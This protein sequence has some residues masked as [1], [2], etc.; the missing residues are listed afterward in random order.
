M[1]QG[2][3]ESRMR[4]KRQREFANM[5]KIRKNEIGDGFSKKR[6]MKMRGLG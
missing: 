6:K 5:N 3:R 2:L 4:L 1:L